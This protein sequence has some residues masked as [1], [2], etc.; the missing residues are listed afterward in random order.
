MGYA[1]SWL[2]IRGKKPHEV[3]SKLGVEVVGTTSDYGREDLVDTSYMDDRTLL[4]S[5]NCERLIAPPLLEE[6]SVGTQLVACAIEEIDA[7]SEAS[8][9]KKS[10]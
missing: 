6:L 7:S 1:L 9:R 8:A 4:I 3:D 5:R 2:A 10:L